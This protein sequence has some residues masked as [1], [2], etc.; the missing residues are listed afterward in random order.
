MPSPYE[1]GF[2]REETRREY[3][4]GPRS[5]PAGECARCGGTIYEVSIRAG[6]SDGILCEG[7]LRYIN[8][9]THRMA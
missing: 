3:D 2:W 8:G 7:C 5:H 4:E 1:L 6:L 9:R